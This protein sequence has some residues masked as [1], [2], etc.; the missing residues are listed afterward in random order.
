MSSMG[1]FALQ[2]IDEYAI[3]GNEKSINIWNIKLKDQSQPVKKI[4]TK[5]NVTQIHHDKIS[6]TVYFLIK[7]KEGI[8]SEIFSWSLD[9]DEPKKRSK[10]GKKDKK[11]RDGE[12]DS[13]ESSHSYSYS[14]SESATGMSD[15]ESGRNRHD[16]K[17]SLKSKI[18]RTLKGDEAEAYD[19][20]SHH[21]EAK[22]LKIS[23]PPL[24]KRGLSNSGSGVG[25]GSSGGALSPRVK[26]GHD[27]KKLSRSRYHKLE[28]KA[29]SSSLRAADA[30]ED[31]ES[32]TR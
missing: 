20:I 16:K 27:D 22:R 24:D 6:N 23:S 9:A 18:L 15:S 19:D 28:S 26:V 32:G 5:G 12:D 10:R 2:L 1:L 17:W 31:S 21:I 14:Y 25:N 8:F 29:R 11:R 7:N 13:D 3:C 30:D 4:K